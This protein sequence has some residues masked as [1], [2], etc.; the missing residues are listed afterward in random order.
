MKAKKSRKK[1]HLLKTTYKV[2]LKL[3]KKLTCQRNERVSQLWRLFK[4]VRKIA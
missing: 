4:M 1:S 3:L 2:Q